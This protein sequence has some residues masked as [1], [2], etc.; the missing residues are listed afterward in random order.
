MTVTGTHHRQVGEVLFIPE[1]R[2]GNLGDEFAFTFTVHILV[3]V[4]GLWSF[5][6]SNDVRLLLTMYVHGQSLHLGHGG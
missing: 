1:T 6:G 4:C 5:C 2:R 3:D